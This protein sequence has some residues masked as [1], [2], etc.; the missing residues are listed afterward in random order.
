[1]SEKVLLTKKGKEDLEKELDILVHQKRAEASEKIRIA[2][3]FGDLSENA[4]YD[5]A[6]DEQAKIEARIA[7][8]EQ[9]L[10]NVEIIEEK[11]GDSNTVSIGD[12]VKVIE[13]KRKK[14]MTLKIVG[15]LEADLEQKKIS[16]ESPL[17]KALIN[18]KKDSII[19][20]KTKV[21]KIQYKVLEI[22]R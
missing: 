22:I 12:T 16:N 9:Q 21:G 1:M 6:K 3:G 19:E 8:I 18:S 14:E 7:E 11:R 20:V 4:E 2:R 17:G 10:K 15:T 5:E 13:L